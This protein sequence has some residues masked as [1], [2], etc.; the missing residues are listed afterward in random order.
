MHP[1]FRERPDVSQLRAIRHL[2]ELM[3]ERCEAL[4]AGRVFD[5]GCGFASSMLYAAN[6][7]P[8][9]VFSGICASDTEQ[10]TARV[11]IR[12]AGRN[13]TVM[14]FRGDYEESRNYRVFPIQDIVYAFDSYRHVRDP[15]V[16]LGLL[17][18]LVRPSGRLILA[19]LFLAA[20]EVPVSAKPLLEAWR[21]AAG[22]SS[23]HSVAATSRLAEQSGFI[24]VGDAAIHCSQA[25]SLQDRLKLL[26]TM[27]HDLVRNTAA[28]RVRQTRRLAAA[29]VKAGLLE[30]RVL[31]FI[32]N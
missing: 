12:E 25:T 24:S 10:E 21:M 3:L 31:E 17:F 7:R 15:A 8:Q 27:P 32:R 2:E 11:R 20:P 30:Y 4:D 6:I 23:V 28:G 19:D 13:Q 22:I 29:A 9:T 5:L 14:A 1:A 16:L 26:L 18:Q